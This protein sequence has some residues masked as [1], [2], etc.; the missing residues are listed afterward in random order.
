MPVL[1]YRAYEEIDFDHAMSHPSTSLINAYVIRKALIR[2][3][4]LSTTIANW[5]SKYPDSALKRHFKPAIDFELDF[6]EF[7]DEALLE[8]YELRE[9]LEQNESKPAS[10]KE[11]WI[12]KPGMSD[13][14]QGIRLFNSEDQLQAIFEEWEVD[15]SDLDEDDP[16]DIGG[17]NNDESGPKLD[18]RNEQGVVTSQLRHFIAQPYIHPPLNLPSAAGRKFHIRT[19]VLAVGSL[20]VY[21]FKEM[22]AL[23]AEKPYKAPWDED[24]DSRDLSRHLTNTCLQENGSSTEGTVRRY[25]SLDDNVPGVD[26]GWKDNVFDQICTVTGQ[27]FEA[28]SRG[29]LVH[30]QTLPNAFEL[31]GLDYLVD[32]TGHAWLLEVNAFPDFAQ[33]G[34]D[35]KQVVVGRLFEATINVAILPF[36]T[37]NSVHAASDPDL[38][39]VADLD[40]GR[41]A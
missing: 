6:A 33:T 27:T 16:D 2:K 40:L 4:Y 1:Q 18:P 41:T 34:D 19:Y 13:R 14:G 36:F 21:V 29:M 37:K 25:W 39:L 38:K 22:L 23:F 20:K 30:F 7:L 35:L 26:D 17:P 9:S 31:F 28:A 12:L 15:E 11:W 3:H 8:A 10:E 5:V 32:A 24:D